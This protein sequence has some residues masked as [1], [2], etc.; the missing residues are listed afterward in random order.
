M[1]LPRT[2]SALSMLLLPTAAFAQDGGTGGPPFISEVRIDQSG[3]DD[4]EYFELIGAPNSSLDGVFYIVIG[5]GSG[6]SG[7]IEHITDLTGSSLGADG[8]F[9]AAEASFTLGIADLTT[10][11]NF[12]NGDNVTH[13]LV[14]GST[15]SVGDDLDTNDD[16]ILDLTPWFGA[17]DG[18]ALI[19]ENNPPSG[20]E[21]H[22]GGYAGVVDTVGPDGAFVP[23]HAFEC[24]SGWAAG[25]FGPVGLTDTPGEPNP[26]A[27][28]AQLNELRVDQG[29]G[30]D[31]EYFEL[32]GP[33][34]WSLDG[35]TYLVIG[36]SSGGMSGVIENATDLTGLAIGPSGYFVAAEGTFTLG[37]ADL[38]TSLN[39]ENGDNVTHFLVEGFSGAVGDD[40]DLD[41]DGV[42]DITPW[43]AVGSGVALIEEL[44]PPTGTE[45]HYGTDLGLPILG[46]DGSFVPA[47]ALLCPDGWRIGAFTLG[48]TDTPG[49]DNFCDAVTMEFCTPGEPN[50]VSATG[51]F[52][53]MSG[54]GSVGGNDNALVINDTPDFFGLFVQADMTMPATMSP[55]GGNVCISGTVERMNMI[56]LPIGNTATLPLD[57]EGTGV[58]SSTT[59]GVTSYYQWFHRDMT[60]G[61]GNYSSG[62][63]VTWAP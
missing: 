58:E 2:I 47:Q 41:D 34:G 62:L 42:L 12:E 54:S 45:F 28:V 52:I 33:A 31:D 29:G 30:D 14:L 9:V 53:T 51:S 44:N 40:L 3:G 25:E 13:L 56:L 1:N 8:R 36:D 10:S 35:L 49:A 46:P 37:T 57:F 16:G 7:T 20:T 6:G 43:M 11:L 48:A 59:A 21:Y 38:T 15:A 19:E 23:A 26:C 5:D 63:A 27:G 32:A 4:D 50:S 22:Y 60:A 24:S 17:L 55:I 61:G 39:F 18:I